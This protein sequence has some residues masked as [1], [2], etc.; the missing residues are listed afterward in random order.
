MTTLPPYGVKCSSRGIRRRH[1]APTEIYS[2]MLPG[3]SN[4]TQEAKSRIRETF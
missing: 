3:I 1:L 4:A 2:S